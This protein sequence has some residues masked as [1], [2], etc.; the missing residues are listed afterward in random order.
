MSASTYKHIGFAQLDHMY[1]VKYRCI[2]DKVDLISI[3][4]SPIYF[5]VV[6]NKNYS[7]EWYNFYVNGKV[8]SRSTYLNGAKT[9]S[10][11]Y[12]SFEDLMYRLYYRNGV[13]NKVEFYRRNG[14]ISR[15]LYESFD[16]SE[17]ALVCSKNFL[18]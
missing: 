17:L 14:D 2:A 18:Y 5:E 3:I 15:V 8:Y 11:I 12:S 7:G 9:G 13:C 1:K 4:S 10:E 6:P 16:E